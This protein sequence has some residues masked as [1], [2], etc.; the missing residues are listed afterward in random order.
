M[1]PARD[2]SR[3]AISGVAAGM[4]R[5]APAGTRPGREAAED[6]WSDYY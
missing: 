6:L 4:S 5:I 3:V 1:H 2:G